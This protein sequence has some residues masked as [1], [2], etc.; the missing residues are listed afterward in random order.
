VLARQQ[1]AVCGWHSLSAGAS[2][3]SA[4]VHAEAPRDSVSISLP[5]YRLR[6]TVFV[7]HSLMT[8]RRSFTGL[9]TQHMQPATPSMVRR[10]EA[11]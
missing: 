2:L 1:P 3:G 10:R 5:N 9:A 7:F 11:E 4:L 6:N 8:G